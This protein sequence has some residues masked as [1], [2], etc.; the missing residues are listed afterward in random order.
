MSTSCNDPLIASLLLSILPLHLHIQYNKGRS[1]NSN[2]SVTS[3]A[4]NHSYKHL[5]ELAKWL[6]TTF[7]SFLNKEIDVVDGR[8]GMT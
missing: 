8:N 5:I 6:C 1:N 4:Q 2:N 7:K 3:E